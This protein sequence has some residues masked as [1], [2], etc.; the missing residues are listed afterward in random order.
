MGG[1]V[2][3]QDWTEQRRKGQNI[4]FILLLRQVVSLAAAE[5]ELSQITGF[6]ADRQVPAVVQTQRRI[7]VFLVEVASSEPLHKLS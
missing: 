3:R 4:S 7:E 2:E 1:G 5:R 6:T